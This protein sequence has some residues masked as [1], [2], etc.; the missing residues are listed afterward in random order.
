MTFPIIAL[1]WLLS[2]ASVALWAAP[3]W[4]VGVLTVAASPLAFPTFGRN[5][6]LILLAAGLLALVGGGRF[7]SWE[8]RPAP[9]IAAYLGQGVLL[10]G[11][12]ASEP[13][14][15]ITTASYEIDVRSVTLAGVRSSTA[16][17]VRV[18]LNQYA[19]YL[20]GDEVRVSGRLEAAPVFP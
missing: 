13:D 1:V 5:G 12:V 6:A 14:P 16:G 18:T 11:E 10:E 8:A 7:Q 15:G 2:I 17:K 20:P 9:G 3:W 19:D 4:S